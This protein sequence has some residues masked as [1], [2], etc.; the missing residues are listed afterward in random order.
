LPLSI[1]KRM[2]NDGATV[3]AGGKM[4]ISGRCISL[5]AATY[6]FALTPLLLAQ[7]VPAAILQVDIDNYVAYVNDTADVANLATDT[8]LTT[9][10]AA[11]K[12]F[13]TLLGIAD[14][15]AVNG[16]P[17][18][19]TWIVKGTWIN[20]TPDAAPGQAVADA[21]RTFIIESVWE[22]QQTDGR[23][24]GTI[25]GAGLAFGPPQPGAPLALLA[26]AGG[27]TA[28][29]GGTGAF[30]G[31]RGQAGFSAINIGGRVART[32]SVNE[33]PSR[34]RA[35]GGGART[36][37]LHLIPM[38][39][40]EVVSDQT[41][42]VVLHSSDFSRVTSASPARAGETLTLTVSGLGPTRPGVDPGE[43]FP[44]FPENG[45][46]EVN[47]SVD[48]SVNGGAAEVVNK[49][50]WPGRA[51]TYRIDVRVPE[52]TSAGSAAVRITA[53]YVRGSEFNIPVR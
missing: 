41:R 6:F 1:L 11:A 31:A 2:A 39:L 33:D 9:S 43:S 16:K 14:I 38:S 22:I 52:G 36:W 30:L 53:G 10:P 50:G 37:L 42:P 7:T 5:A 8:N 25:I 49:I 18:R 4:L 27:A 17:A 46:Q 51:N 19:G 28:I 15:V 21:T 40:P 13:A 45:L 3:T 47:S 24:T 29:T 48:V 44:P 26:T 35:L 23:P 34:R 20:L 32:S 12:T